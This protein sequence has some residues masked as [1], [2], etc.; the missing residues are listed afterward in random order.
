M[1]L[2]FLVVAAR[3][4]RAGGVLWSLKS[5]QEV[6]WH[7]VTSVGSLVVGMDDAVT[8]YSP[9]N[10]Q[11]LWQR[12]ELK[13]VS[14]FQVTE[15]VGTPVL[16]IGD[17]EGSKAKL[18]ALD[19]LTGKSIWESERIKGAAVGV[20]PIYEKSMVLLLTIRDSKMSKDKPDMIAFDLASGEVLWESEFADKV[21]LHAVGARTFITRYD[22]SGHQPPVADGDSLYFTYAGLHRY[23]LATGKLLWSV[24]YDVTEGKLKRGNAQAVVA[25]DTI[26]TSAKGVI[27][28]IEKATGKV[29]WMSKD[30]GAA[31]AEMIVAGNR[32]YGRMGGSFFDWN[33]KE[34]TL[35]KPLGVVAVHKD[36]GNTVWRY[37][38]A[39]DSIT[40]MVLLPEQNSLLIADAQ[41]LIGLDTTAEGEVKESLKMKLE[42]K[43]KIS[44]GKKAARTA[45][46][47]A[48]KG[49]MGFAK[50]D[51][52]DLD[53]P[54]A[55]SLRENGLAVVR[56]KQHLLA[57]DPKSHDI[58]WSLEY[59]PPGIP[60]WKFIVMTAMAM[61]SYAE[62]T[63]RAAHTELGTT[64]NN[65]ANRQRREIMDDY[66]KAINQRFTASK[67]NGN[68]V[69]VLTELEN[70]KDKVPGLVGINL[71]TG[72][73]DRE[74]AIN[75][76]EPDYQVDET[77][78]R[79]FNVKDKKEII[80][81]SAN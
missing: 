19:I 78:G 27:R 1:V 59:N 2:L 17:T 79:V 62:A 74:I 44:G 53:A 6:K 49:L 34:W 33:E 14:E 68:Y 37:D 66:I 56:G 72:V 18:Y 10:G 36:T 4:L 41:R 9:D 76:K 55:I 63:N 58:P 51:K 46:K 38:D 67:T 77:A 31:V 16:L 42:F 5:P 24:P 80:A 3:E 29:K 7:R 30:F 39:K 45:A 52:S 61:A 25:G 40:N 21:D 20:A 8:C 60:G 23:D 64:A 28:A 22:L 26:Y 73:A 75:D 57:F 48:G 81:L 54:V 15:V 32:V 50:K 11:A 47:F 35:K 12:P 43:N 71:D 69:Y 13:K 65:F 70:G